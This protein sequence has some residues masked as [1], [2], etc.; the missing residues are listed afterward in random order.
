MLA[1]CFIQKKKYQFLLSRSDVHRRQI[2]SLRFRRL[3]GGMHSALSQALAT[4]WYR[5]HDVMLKEAVLA[6]QQDPPGSKCHLSQ[7][8]K[9]KQSLRKGRGRERPC[10]LHLH[11]SLEEQPLLYCCW[12]F[13]VKKIKSQ[14]SLEDFKEWQTQVSADL[15]LP[16]N[17]IE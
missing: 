10:S 1:L 14:F 13:S 16:S 9:L 5:E 4:R 17:L 7:G 3:D 2:P 15:R 12:H 11:H 6:I 8:K